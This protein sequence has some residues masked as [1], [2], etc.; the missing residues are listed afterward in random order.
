[1]RD[2]HFVGEYRGI[3]FTV[4]W[5]PTSIAPNE[6]EDM[7]FRIIYHSSECHGI[8]CVR[9]YYIVHDIRYLERPRELHEVLFEVHIGLADLRERGRVVTRRIFDT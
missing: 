9:Q 5:L 6:N 7:I 2:I 8:G 4:W 3:T 1:M